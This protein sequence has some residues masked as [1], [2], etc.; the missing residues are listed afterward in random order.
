MTSYSGTVALPA[1]GSVTLA[2]LDGPAT[3]RV[4]RLVVPASAQAQAAIEA[5]NLRITWDGLP[6]ASVDAPV[7]LLFGTG[8]LFNR[9]GNIA[10]KRVCPELF[11]DS[12]SVED[13]GQSFP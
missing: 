4:L 10:Q 9:E 11:R 8:T 1:T 2:D 7:P 3:L 12:L 5:A 13:G 6:S